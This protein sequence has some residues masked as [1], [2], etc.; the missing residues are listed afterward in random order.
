[1]AWPS[2]SRI[3]SPIHRPGGS[4]ET[5]AVL[6][7]AHQHGFDFVAASQRL[8]GHSVVWLSR[9]GTGRDRNHRQAVVAA[10]SGLG[11]HHPERPFDAPPIIVW[12]V[13]T[14]RRRRISVVVRQERIFRKHQPQRQR[15]HRWVQRA[16]G[17]TGPAGLNPLMA[18][19]TAV[20]AQHLMRMVVL[21]Q[22][23]AQSVSIWRGELKASRTG[24]SSQRFP[25]QGNPRPGRNTSNAAGESGV[26][27][28]PLDGVVLLHGRL[29][30]PQVRLHIDLRSL[31]LV[32]LP[33]ARMIL[34]QHREGGASSSRL[35]T[36]KIQCS[37]RML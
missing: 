9:R 35:L 1:M 4:S 17:M 15:A 7:G 19:R 26:P 37:R 5:S 36:A 25:S 8:L 30:Q 34:D 13:G 14:V 22:S 16:G 10:Q 23:S 28:A 20:V 31:P 12:R 2:T 18:R 21:R 32:P 11:H 29:L 27:A 24:S 33:A 6:P 3:S